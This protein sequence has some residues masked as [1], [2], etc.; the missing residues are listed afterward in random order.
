[1]WDTPPVMNRKMTRFA[2]AGKCGGLRSQR[3][4]R[5]DRSC[6]EQLSQHPGHQQP[7]CSQGTNRLSSRHIHLTSIHEQKRVAR[8][9]RPHI[10]RPRTLLTKRAITTCRAML[11][12]QQS[13][14][15]PS[16]LYFRLSADRPKTRL[17]AH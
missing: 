12:G 17:Y 9:H 14:E 13:Q 6:T 1:M 4:V 15:R 16:L 8:K 5:R 3:I 2:F 11:V 10:S 7:A